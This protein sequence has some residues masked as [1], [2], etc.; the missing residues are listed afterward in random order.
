MEPI[1]RTLFVHTPGTRLV[2]DGNSIK[3][4]RDDTQTRRLPLHVI[5]TLVVVGGVDVSTPLLLHCAENQRVVAFL[6][7]F[8][9]PR[10]VVDGALQGRSE[11]RRL[12]YAAHAS[13]N[14]RDELAAGIVAGKLKQM[15]W[16]LRQLARSGKDATAAS[17]RE[18]S[19]SLEVSA[20]ATPGRPRQELLGVEGEASRR[21]FAAYGTT[22]RGSPWRGRQRRPAT[23]PINALLSW[24]YGMTRIAVHGAVAVAG[25]DPGTGFLHGD[26][27]SQSSLVLDLMEEFRPAADALAAKL[28]NT[29]QVNASH[30]VSSVSGAVELTLEGREVLFDAWHKH[31]MT[32]VTLRGRSLTIPHAMVP[33]V[34]AHGLANALRFGAPY[35]AHVRRIR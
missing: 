14:R 2:L 3:A 23:D 7:R 28:W 22:L 34:Q 27:A 31:R 11:L 15:S 4:I 18:V 16:G 35:E 32:A 25:L 5:D 24:C 33:I 6:S 26:R 8:G 21:Y 30:F 20:A 10:A 1:L 17:L 29:K 13:A 12:Q 19:S 9:K